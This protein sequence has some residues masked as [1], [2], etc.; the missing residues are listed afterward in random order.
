MDYLKLDG[1]YNS[2]SGYPA[3][4][5][6]FGSALLNGPR[7]IMFSCSWPAYLGEDETKKPFATMAADGCNLW[8][9]W[10]DIQCSWGSLSSI[11]EHWGKYTEAL[12]KA[13]GPGHWNG[14]IISPSPPSVW[15]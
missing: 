15:T 11:I 12:E 1:C 9:N 5:K 3:G 14:A 4:Y 2:K 6:A 13:A 8:R 7:P 10:A